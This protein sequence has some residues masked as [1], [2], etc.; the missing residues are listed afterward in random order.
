MSATA[1]IAR[2]RDYFKDLGR[3]ERVEVL[4]I[5]SSDI[6]LGRL[7]LLL[8]LVIKAELH[9]LIHDLVLHIHKNEP[10]IEKSILVFLPT[11]RS[12]EQQWS[13]LKPFS[14]SFKVHILHRSIDTEEA[15]MAMKIW[16]SHRKVILATNIAESSVTIPKVAF[17]IDSC[18]SLQVLWDSN[19]KMESSELV[20]VSNSQAEQRKGRTGRTC[21]GQIYRLVTRSFFSQLQ[22]YECPAILRLS[23]R[24]Q[25]LL[26]CCAESKAINDPKDLEK[27][28]V[29]NVAFYTT[30]TAPKALDP[31]DP[32]IVEDALSLLV[33]IRALEKTFPRGRYEPTF[34][35]RLLASFSLSFDASILVLKFGDMGMLREGIL[36]GILMDTQPLPILRPFGKDVLFGKY[37]DCYYSGDNKNTALIGRNEVLY[38][39]NLCAFQFWQCVYKDELRLRRMK[40]HL[41]FDEVG[42]ADILFPRM[43]EKNDE[44]ILSSIHRFRPKFLSTSNGLP[45][46]YESYDFQHACSLSFQHK[47]DADADALAT[48]GDDLELLSETVECISVPFV[49][50][51]YFQSYE[52][53]EKL[54]TIIKEMRVQRSEDISGIEHKNVKVDGSHVPWEAPLNG[55]YVPWEAPLCTFFVKV[56]VLVDGGGDWPSRELWDSMGCRNG[57]ACVFSHDGGPSTSSSYQSSVCLPEDDNVDAASLL[58]LFPTSSDGCILLLDDTGFHISLHLSHHYDPSKI[59]TTTSLSENSALEPSPAG[60]RIHWGLS[61]PYQTIKAED[62][63]VPW[64]DVAC[65]LWFPKFDSNI[66][67]LE[68]QKSIMQTFFEYLAV[69]LMSN[70]LLEVQAILIMNNI[71]FSQLQVEKLG[72]ESFFFLSESFPFD[73]SSF[74]KLSDTVTLKKPLP[75]SKPVS[76]VFSLNPPYEL[77]TLL[78]YRDGCCGIQSSKP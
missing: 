74:G 31:P 26:I 48:D 3:G 40:Q 57:D 35:G 77:T 44:D 50:S 51:N 60:V 36:L 75:V 42:P 34:Y 24:Q 32:E 70:A 59:I 25:V 17:V 12:L 23:L 33:R 38:M 39:A 22:D 45:S 4:A 10:D 73:E 52:V 69:R 46:Y 1:D 7:L 65:I 68:A 71:R 14:T 67:N 8:M 16:E 47:Q 29:H 62:S 11:Y 18:R 20:W 54:A 49:P 13:L 58:R 64:N 2:Y 28:K 19:R 41:H 27:L 55:S 72:R 43:N 21:D 53:A 6:V 15:L 76:Y 37:T 5:P 63:P 9:K 78:W 66:D 56:A 61:H 30:L